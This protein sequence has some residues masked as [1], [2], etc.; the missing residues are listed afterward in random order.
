MHSASRSIH[1]AEGSQDA[2]LSLKRLL[3]YLRP[4]RMQL[5]V[6]A[7]LVVAHNVFNIIGPYLMG[8]AIDDYII[9]GDRAGLT[10]IGLLMVAIYAAMWL[11]GV[12]FGRIMAVISQKTLLVIRRDLFNHM[13]SLSLNFFDKQTAGDL[14]SRLTNDI[15]N[16]GRML[17][18]NVVSL[19]SS[20]TSLVGVLLMMFILNGW[21]TLAALVVIPVMLGLVGIFMTRVRPAFRDLQKNLGQLNGLMEENLS[22]QRVVIAYNRQ[23][24]LLDEF[25]IVNV[26]TRDAGIKANIT[27]GLMGPITMILGNIN[28]AVVAGVG[29]YMAINGMAGVTV[30]LIATFINYTRRFGMPLM[31]MANLFSSIMAALAGAER[32]FEVLD[33]RP[34]V[35]D[36]DGAVSAEGMAGEVIFEQVDFSY[37]GAEKV[38]N[39]VSLRASPGET[40]ALVGP[41]GA[42]KTTIVNVLARF[43]D[44]DSGRIVIDGHEIREIRQDSLRRRLG[45][46][47]QDSFLFADTV[48]ENI[49]YGRLEA[50]DE[51]VHAAAGLANADGFIRRLPHGYETELSERASNLSQGQR[52]LISIARA[53][54]ANPRILILDEAT[55]SVDTRTEMMIQEA[56]LTLMEGRTSFVIAHRLSTIREADQ[57]LVVDEGRIVERGKHDQLLANDGFYRR[58]YESQFKGQA[59]FTEATS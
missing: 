32:I 22:G 1:G 23:E 26:A 46:V 12:A 20:F 9:P 58:L 47:L 54:L 4:Y 16:V 2:R 39:D 50:T 17:A 59:V 27:A 51:E 25:S 57:I 15:D 34:E 7:T 40:I 21:L 30:G 37:D 10:R 43:Y 33:T 36:S 35:Q 38:L 49:R 11:S 28:V 13:Q 42:G 3:V 48:M 8:V 5:V 6:V 56:L 53:V 29:A 14:M 44:I 52:Q 18:Q 55:S 41:T 31:Q 19:I 24:Q 45:I